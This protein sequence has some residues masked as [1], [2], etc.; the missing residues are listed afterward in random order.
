MASD[1]VC[2]DQPDI[3]NLT[4]VIHYRG[5]VKSAVDRAVAEVGAPLVTALYDRPGFIAN[6]RFLAENNR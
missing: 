3:R 2:G 5:C 4:A 6:N 1:E